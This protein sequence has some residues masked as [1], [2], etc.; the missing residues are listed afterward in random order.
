M[1][2]RKDDGTSG[3]ARGVGS[4]LLWLGAHANNLPG[5]IELFEIRLKVSYDDHVEH[6]AVIKAAWDSKPV[7]AFCTA[8]DLDMLVHL[9]AAKLMNGTFKW[10]EDIPYGTPRNNT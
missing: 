5:D 7:V 6:M 8:P 4:E 1:A 10:R 9:V 2:S 3:V